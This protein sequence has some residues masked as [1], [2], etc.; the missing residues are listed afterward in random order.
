MLITYIKL[1]LRNLKRNATFSLISIT[2]LGI[3]LLSCVTVATVVLDNMS[4]DSN[5]ERHD[6][7]YRIVSKAKIGDEVYNKYSFSLAGLQPALMNNF[8]EVEAVSKVSVINY[9]VKT[10]ITQEGVVDFNAIKTDTLVWQLF[11][12]NIKAGKPKDFVYGITNVVITESLK[13]KLFPIEE[14]IGQKIYSVSGFDEEPVEMLITG[15]IE[16]IPSNTHLRSEAVVIEKNRLELLSKSQNA[17]LLTNYLLLRSGTNATGFADKVNKWYEEFLGET[18]R[19]TFEFQPIED[20]YLDS[21]FDE[22]LKVKGDPKVNYILIGVALLL[23]VIGCVNFINLMVANAISKVKDVGVRKIIGSSRKQ[24]IYQFLVESLLYFLIATAIALGL[25][26]LLKPYL[27]AYMAYSIEFSLFKDVGYIMMILV[28]VLVLTLITGIY[29]AFLV[30]GFKSINSI[31]G[32]IFGNRVSGQQRV[33]KVLVVTQFSIALFVLVALF[34]VNS[35]YRFLTSRD[36]GYNPNNLLFMDYVSW[37]G[38]GNTFQS[39][40]NRIKGV[41]LSSMVGWKIT[42]NAGTMYSTVTDPLNPDTKIQVNF[43]MG[44]VHLVET[45]GLELE[46]GRVFDPNRSNDVIKEPEY[47]GEDEEELT[48]V[49]SLIT[50]FTAEKLNVT[51]LDFHVKE[52]QSNPVGILKNFHTKSLHEDLVPTVIKAES[53]PSWSGM[54]IRVDEANQKETLASIYKVWE[55]FYPNNYFN[56]EWVDELVELQYAKEAKLYG[57][58]MFFGVLCLL[59]AAMGVYGL[60]AQSTQQR[61]K[62]IGIRKVLGASVSRIIILFSKEYFK[63]VLLAILIAAPLAWYASSQWLEDFAYRINI[64]WTLLVV[65]GFIV[66][67]VAIGTASIQSF[68][69]AMSNPSNSLKSE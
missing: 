20:V 17:T 31:K 1:A 30:S 50:R 67:I 19:Y 36:I 40:I 18:P 62:E 59:L 6:D 8:S 46:E 13:K 47:G 23:L 55:N 37:N 4:Y 43:I 54:L 33:Q 51:A 56:V 64:K 44:D 22:R 35:Q 7:L 27:E 15:I 11:N 39:E 38:K 69:A 25:Y 34:V 29:P 48:K 45:L 57:F 12:F 3:G 61:I 10:D 63:M 28:M 49:S 32:Q 9:H 21:A 60:V 68:K 58:F 42:T 53:D 66:T 24:I 65:A 41:E 14:A 16:D 26:Q 2:G 5:W 52:L